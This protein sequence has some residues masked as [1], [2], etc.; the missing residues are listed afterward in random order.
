MAPHWNSTKVNKNKQ[1]GKILNVSHLSEIREKFNCDEIP[2]TD[3]GKLVPLK[4]NEYD[5]PKDPEGELKVDENGALKN[6]KTYKFK[7]FTIPT[8]PNKEKLYVLATD[9]AKV[10]DYKR[11]AVLFL[12]HRLSLFKSY[13]SEDEKKYLLDNTTV[14]DN[15]TPM[16]LTKS[17]LVITAKSLFREFGHKAVNDGKPLNDDYYTTIFPY[18]KSE[19]DVSSKPLQ[20]VYQ[21]LKPYMNDPNAVVPLPPKPSQIEGIK[22]K[23]SNVVASKHNERPEE[24]PIVQE[25][26]VLYQSVVNR[27]GKDININQLLEKKINKDDKYINVSVGNKKVEIP[28]DDEIFSNLPPTWKKVYKSDILSKKRSSL[29]QE[30]KSRRIL[31]LFNMM[32]SNLN[33]SLNADMN[34]ENWIYL[35]ADACSKSNYDMYENRERWQFITNRGV[36]DV[37]TNVLHVPEFT[38][39]TKVIKKTFTNGN[40]SK[41]TISLQDD[42]IYKVKTGLTKLE[43]LEDMIQLIDDNEI[44]EAIKAQV[45]YEVNN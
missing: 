28:N 19:E 42:D 8:R 41:H 1:Y 15:V 25:E 7:T 21:Y 23:Y 2:I 40:E 35:H 38:Q 30:D 22:P 24:K 11:A 45:D 29:L 43:G 5:L 37:Y 36:R 34:Q 3:D 27:S 20:E 10:F 12:N 9:A 16:N 39:S 18:E 31:D 32:Q 26:K 6:N 13:L 14:L 44:K 33:I 4:D 17:I